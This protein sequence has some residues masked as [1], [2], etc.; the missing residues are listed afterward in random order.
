MADSIDTHGIEAIAAETLAARDGRRQI[1]P[2]IDRELGFDLAAGYRVSAAHRRLREA[3]GERVVGRKLGF[4]NRNLWPQFGVGAPIYGDL[5]D[6]TCR[7]V[8]PEGAEFDLS[9]MLEPKIEP[10]LAFGLA[11]A[12]EPG[13]DEAALMGCVGWV[14]HGI[15]VVQSLYPGWKFQAPDTVAGFTMHGAYLL[16]PRHELAPG[17]AASLLDLIG[18]FHITILRDGEVMDRGHCSDVLGNPLTALRHL[19]ELLDKDPDNPQLSPGEYVTTGTVTKVFDLAPGQTWETRVEG[20]PLPG[21][22]VSFR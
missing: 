9:A 4:T 16:G 17:E 1:A 21:L 22:R 18:D 8:S 14:V 11:R 15:E 19:V 6:S 5:F 13:M 10:E 7:E 12:P 3:R 2:L 20:L